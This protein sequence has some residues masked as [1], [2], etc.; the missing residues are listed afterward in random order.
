MRSVP[1]PKRVARLLW[2]PPAA[3]ESKYAAMNTYFCPQQKMKMDSY[4]KTRTDRIFLKFGATVGANVW[5][6]LHR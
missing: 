1:W 4:Y 3:N 6:L 2:S 5:S